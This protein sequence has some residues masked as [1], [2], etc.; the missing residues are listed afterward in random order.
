MLVKL[1]RDRVGDPEEESRRLAAG[2][3]EEQ[4]AENRVLGHVRTLAKHG[5][6]GAEARPEVGDRGERED[7]RRPEDDRQPGG[8]GAR[9]RH[10]A[11]LVSAPIKASGKG[12]RCKSGTVPPL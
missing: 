12:N 8:N 1:V 4:Q 3:A 11:M 5:V 7:H 6:P 10:G 9:S 2:W